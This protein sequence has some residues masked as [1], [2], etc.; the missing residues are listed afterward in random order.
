MRPKFTVPDHLKPYQRRMSAN[1]VGLHLYDSGPVQAPGPTFLLIHGLGDEADSWRKV[2]PLLTGQGRVVA[3]D[4]PGFGRSEHPRR[5]YTLNFFADTLAALLDNLKVPQAVL[6]GSSLGAAVALRLAQRRADLVARLVL[7]GGPPMRGRLNRVQLMFL[8]PGQG[9][10][11]YNSFRSSQE[12]A[13]ES[14][15][16]YYASLEAL[17]PEDRQFLRE[18]VWDRVWS[19]DQRRAYFSTFRWM[20]LESLL[21]RARL[22][23]VKTPTLLVWGEQDAVVPLEAAKALQGSMTNAKLHVIPGCGHLPQQEKPLELARLILQ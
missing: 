8:I 5:A 9:E 11:L 22:G 23:Q 19:D 2:F 16:P 7:V 15:R 1:G 13:Y 10:K 3:P 21:G 6:V 18:R 17:P 20:A 12:A 14:L 4:L